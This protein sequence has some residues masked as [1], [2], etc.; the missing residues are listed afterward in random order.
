MRLAHAILALAA[1]LVGCV[2][3]PVRLASGVGGAVVD[4]ATREPIEGA[5]VVVRSGRISS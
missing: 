4:A 2:P 1:L 5:V 3:M